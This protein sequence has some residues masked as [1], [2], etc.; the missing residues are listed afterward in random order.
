MLV[1][2]ISARVEDEVLEDWLYWMKNIHIP[3]VMETGLFL[4]YK[5]MILLNDPLGDEYPGH[6]FIIQYFADTLDQYDQYQLNHAPA[7]QQKFK[8]R[9]GDKVLTFRTLMQDV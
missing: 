8:D 4:D 5:L 1:Y 3:E 9:Y 2:N 7:L 6:T